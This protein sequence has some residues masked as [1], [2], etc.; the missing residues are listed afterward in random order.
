MMHINK[1]GEHVYLEKCQEDHCETV[2][3]ENSFSLK[4]EK[5]EAHMESED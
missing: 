3:L 2:E 4:K 5:K 1:Q